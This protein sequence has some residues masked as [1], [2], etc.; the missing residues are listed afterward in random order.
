MPHVSGLFIY[1]VKSCR[2]HRVDV[3]ALDDYGFVGDRRFLVVSPDGK[4][5]TQRQLPQ[6]ARIETEL[7]DGH[8]TLSSE[9]FGA[10]SVPS[11]STDAARP[12][13]VTVWKDTVTADDCGEE[14]AD[15]LTRFL[16]LPARLVRMGDGFRREIPPRKIPGTLHAHPF[17]QP[18]VSFA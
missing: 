6:M 16:D 1:P 9:N 18:Q 2:G 12:L 13:S 10:V 17:A 11:A 4:F 7:A 8:L 15:W 14:A 3:A 5:L